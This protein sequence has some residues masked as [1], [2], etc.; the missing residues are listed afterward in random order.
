MDPL[1]SPS[2][3]PELL[4]G[5]IPTSLLPRPRIPHHLS[6]NIPTVSRPETCPCWRILTSLPTVGFYG[7]DWSSAHVSKAQYDAWAAGE[8]GGE[9]EPTPTTAPP[10][11]PP[12]TT[13]T[14]AVSQFTR[15]LLLHELAELDLRSPHLT[16]TS[17]LELAQL[18]L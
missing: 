8:T 6:L 9:P 13:P 10:T 14:V 1:V 3:A 2:T 4:R 11:T 15:F 18:V 7:I 17:S 12:T 16:I 5:H